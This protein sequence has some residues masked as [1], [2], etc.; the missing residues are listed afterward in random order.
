MTSKAKERAEQSAAAAVV[1]VVVVVTAPS[2][3]TAHRVTHCGDIH[4]SLQRIN[5]Q[6]RFRLPRNQSDAS[7]VNNL[8]PETAL[9]EA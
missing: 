4:T 5:S 7:D 9:L 2:C 8:I 3:I 1:V 6:G